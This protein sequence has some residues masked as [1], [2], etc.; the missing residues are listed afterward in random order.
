MTH[1]DPFRCARHTGAQGLGVAVGLALGLVL[2][3]ASGCGPRPAERA[4]AAPAA[5]APSTTPATTG[6][7][8]A[9]TSVAAYLT[10]GELQAETDAQRQELR[11]ALTD[12][13]ERPASPLAPPSKALSEEP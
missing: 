12:L 6:S 1:E 3:L 11:R 10:D 9:A 13:L 4:P 7:E 5:S 8:Q 2:A